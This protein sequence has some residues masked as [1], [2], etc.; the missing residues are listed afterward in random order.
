MKINDG[1]L[2]S[3]KFLASCRYHLVTVN[4]EWDYALLNW[5][6]RA[7]NKQRLDLSSAL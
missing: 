1:F 7:S 2:V 3:F 6:S 4:S 5:D